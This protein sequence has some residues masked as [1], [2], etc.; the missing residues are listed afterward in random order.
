[1]RRQVSVDECLPEPD[2]AVED[3]GTADAAL[4]AEP[5]AQAL[6]VQQEG[7]HPSEPNGRAADGHT[8]ANGH[9]A[10][11]SRCGCCIGGL[12]LAVSCLPHL[13]NLHK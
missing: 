10:D 13:Q 8:P 3:S 1:M 11:G 6:A 7:S 5:S 12:Y 9:A 4:P 2:A